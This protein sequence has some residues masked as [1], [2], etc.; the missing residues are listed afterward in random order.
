MRANWLDSGEALGADTLRA[1]GV[2]YERLPVEGFRSPVDALK[3]ERG[4]VKED[5]VELRPST[6][7]LD[8]ICAKFDCEHFH[9]D[10]EVR[11]ILEGEGIFDVRSLDDR[12]MRIVVEVADLIVVP[13][14]RYHR[15]LLTDSRTVRA[16]RLFKDPSGW[17]PRYRA[18]S[19]EP[20]RAG[21]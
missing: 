13:A 1:E 3:L 6:P 8:A 12:F 9:D 7:G 19:G 5:V 15:F 2:L 21:P 14:G 18:A 10:D 17:V 11:F 16:V 20:L 4:Y